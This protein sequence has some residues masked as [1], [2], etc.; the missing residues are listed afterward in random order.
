MAPLFLLFEQRPKNVIERLVN[1]QLRSLTA[2]YTLH[3]FVVLARV[4]IKSVF[5]N[6]LSVLFNEIHDINDILQLLWSFLVKCY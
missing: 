6:D 2:T 3:I 5:Y 4:Q 1:I